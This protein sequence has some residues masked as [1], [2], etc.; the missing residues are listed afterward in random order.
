[1]GKMIIDQD[2][3]SCI[4]WF[5]LNEVPY[6]RTNPHMERFINKFKNISQQP[7]DQIL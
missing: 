2:E 1:M 4:I 7:V 6:D 5:G 3:F